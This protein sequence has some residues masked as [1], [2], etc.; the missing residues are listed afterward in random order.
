MT[1]VRISKFWTEYKMRDGQMVGVDWAEYCAVGMAQR[2]S[3][4]DPINRLSR[5]M[6]EAAAD[7]PAARMALDR[8]NAI[9]PAYEAWKAGQDLPVN[10]T[11]LAAWAGISQEQA[12]G[13]KMAG[14]RTVEELADATESVITRVPLP[15]MRALKDMAALFLKSSDKAK[16]AD[17]MATMARE[18]Q[19]LKDE[20]EEMR[21]IVLEMQEELR[22]KRGRR[23][24]GS[25]EPQAEAV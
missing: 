17:E 3:T 5:V 22:Q 20:Q 9:K 15:N 14:I 18:N 6:P 8:W 2:A 23:K 12:E 24:A 13:L 4:C 19:A 1:S 25:D 7:N 10:G 11:P 16:I 21:R